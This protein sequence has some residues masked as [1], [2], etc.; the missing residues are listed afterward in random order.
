MTRHSSVPREL[1]PVGV[2]GEGGWKTFPITP[3]PLNGDTLPPPNTPGEMSTQSWTY[4]CYLKIY[5]FTDPY[6]GPVRRRLVVVV[7]TRLA[8]NPPASTSQMQGWDFLDR[9]PSHR[10]KPNLLDCFT[11]FR[12][13]DIYINQIYC[14]NWRPVQWH[15]LHPPHCAINRIP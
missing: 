10:K 15:H 13:V 3:N 7:E 8:F 6:T 14:F 11:D 1:D 5:I 9:T 12:A 2:A 4:F